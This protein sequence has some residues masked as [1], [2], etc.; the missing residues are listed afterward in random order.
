[1]TVLLVLVSK[2]QFDFMFKKICFISISFWTAWWAYSCHCTLLWFGEK[3]LGCSLPA[4]TLYSY[5][6]QSYIWVFVHFSIYTNIH[7]CRWK[8]LKRTGRKGPN[9]EMGRV[10]NFGY[11]PFSPFIDLGTNLVD[12]PRSYALST[13]SLD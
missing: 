9:V 10:V 8:D 1:M 7:L 12:R 3:L 13:P 6:S 5:L 2:K 4:L 11:V